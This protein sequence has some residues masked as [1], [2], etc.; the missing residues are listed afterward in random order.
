[1]N[2]LI[3]K[4]SIAALVAWVLLASCTETEFDKVVL[5]TTDVAGEYVVTLELPALDVTDV[6]LIR[7]FN[8]ASS[9]DSL[10]IEDPD[11]FGTQV[12]VGLNDD[13]TFGITNGVDILSGISLDI[14][15]KVFPEKDS[16]HIEWL[17]KDVDIGLGED[18]YQVIA[19]GVVYD[20]LD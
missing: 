17:Y 18:D 1:M 14:T 20:G 4:Y 15:G 19:N 6:Q 5:P 2:K 9:F 3:R 10:W 16:I 8:T 13:N 11:F 12:K 7:V